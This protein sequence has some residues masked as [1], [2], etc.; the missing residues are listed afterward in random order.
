[1]INI[2][3]SIDAIGDDIELSIE[4]HFYG[5]ELVIDAAYDELSNEVG[6]SLTDSEQEE[7]HRL[8][9]KALQEFDAVWD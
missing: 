9:D 2:I 3:L 1:M 8:T 5:D 4:S 6:D 7:L